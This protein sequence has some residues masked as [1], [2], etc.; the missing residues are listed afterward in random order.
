MDRQIHVG[1]APFGRGDE[2]RIRRYCAGEELT[3]SPLWE[4]L[5]EGSLWVF[6]VDLS[7]PK[8]SSGSAVRA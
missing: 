4:M 2:D 1:K 8:P 7:A 6:G 3:S 5:A